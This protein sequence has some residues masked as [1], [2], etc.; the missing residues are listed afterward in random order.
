M[1]ERIDARGLAC[2]QPVL[3]AKKTLERAGSL[4]VMVDNKTAVENLR[5]FAQSQNCTFRVDERG[6]GEFVL[7][8]EKGPVSARPDETV[9]R[10]GTPVHSPLQA[11]LAVVLSHDRMGRGDDELGQVLMRSFLHTLAEMDEIPA[12]VALYN[13]GVKL[14]VEGSDVIDDLRALQGRGVDIMVCGTCL[15]YFN[16]TD[17]LA[18]GRVSNMYDIAAC[19]TT[20]ARLVAP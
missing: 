17:R 7:A 5:R 4:E 18:A 8:I 15:N 12:R 11:D 16:L 6:P 13:T 3:L 9:T 10:K 2:P 1:P 20:A 19:M 14:A